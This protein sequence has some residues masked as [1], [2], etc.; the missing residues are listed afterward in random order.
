M[1]DQSKALY[2]YMCQKIVGTEE[3]VKTIRTMNAVRDNL[4]S[5]GK[6][7]DITSGSFGE[8][9]EMRGSDLDLMRVMICYEVCENT[10]ITF[11][12]DK[13]YFKMTTE[14]TQLGFTL[15]RLVHCHEDYIFKLCEQIG[16]E[17][18]FSNIYIKQRLSNKHIP[19][20]HGPC[21]SDKNGLCDIAYCLHSKSWI[22]QAQQWITRSSSAWPGY[23]VQQSIITH[24]VLFVPKGIQGSTKE[25]LEWRISFSVGEKILISTFTHTQLLC[26]ALLKILLKDVINIDLY[27][28]ELLCSYFLKTILFWISE[29][30]PITIWRPANLISN[31]MSCLKRLTYC[32][33]NSVCP[34]YFIPE[35]NLFE[36]KMKGHAQET[37]LKKLK[38]L[39]SYGWQCILLSDQISYVNELESQINK[40]VSY[41]PVNSLGLIL[42]PL[43]SL[44]NCFISEDNF[45]LEKGVHGVLSFNSSKIKYLLSFYMSKMGCHKNQSLPFDEKY[46]NKSTYKQY[47][48]RVSSLLLNTRHDAVSGWLM[49]ASFFY[50]TKNYKKAIDILQYSLLKCSPEKLYA[51]I[52]LSD[53][54]Y[55]LF[56]SSVLRQMNFVQLTNMYLV[57]PVLLTRNSTIIPHELRT[58][59]YNAQYIIPAVIY[60]K[61]LQ[62]LCHLHLNNIIECQLS[63]RCLQ[64]IIETEYL[65]SKTNISEK[66][67]AYNILGIAFQSFGDIESSRQAFLKSVQLLPD[68]AFGDAPQRL[69]AINIMNI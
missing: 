14:D 46:A 60:A 53:I 54:Q 50:R 65:I 26:Y 19:N 63:L 25:E 43:I 48:T 55:A 57:N 12:P 51:D 40:E 1:Q 24:G 10:N 32:V 16:G 8:G 2:Q 52:Y 38:T 58:E 22:S 28:K 30:L 3:H 23:E 37:L 47:K 20:I 39:N 5:I 34:H 21:I 61:F 4:S 6:R 62:F 64:L 67:M 29:E 56:S 13:T 42:S 69:A 11:D 35:N 31:F 17:Y 15:L 41:F 18:Y 66:A 45:S 68:P 7:T 27:C 36:N 59:G 44:T 9:L 33:E 49:L